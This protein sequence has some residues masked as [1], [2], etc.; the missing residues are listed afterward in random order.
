MTWE[1]VNIIITIIITCIIIII[2]IIIIHVSLQTIPEAPDG[3]GEAVTNP[4]ILFIIQ[5]FKLRM[6]AY[7]V[8]FKGA[9]QGRPP[10]LVAPS[11]YHLPLNSHTSGPPLSPLQAPWPPW[12]FPMHIMESSM[13]PG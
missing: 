7:T 3:G 1:L 8:G 11:R 12:A 2:I 13:L 5:D 10:Q 6:F 9:A 4:F